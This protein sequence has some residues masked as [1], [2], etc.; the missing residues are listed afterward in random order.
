MKAWME[1]D[2]VDGVDCNSVDH[3]LVPDESPTTL[4][5][6]GKTHTFK[7]HGSHRQKGG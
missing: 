2:G 3:Q 7:L 6:V 4:T 5:G 1:L